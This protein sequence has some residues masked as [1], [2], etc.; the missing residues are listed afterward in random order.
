MKKDANTPATPYLVV[1]LGILAVSTASILIR[2]AQEHASS[3]TIA[4]F[5]LG[6]SALILLPYTF[7]KYPSS[8]SYICQIGKDIS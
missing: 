7:L 2:F 8:G 6:I 5:R 1:P 3:L 4:A